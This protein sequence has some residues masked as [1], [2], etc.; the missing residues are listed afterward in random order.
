MGYIEID[1]HLDSHLAAAWQISMLTLD[2]AS[3]YGTTSFRELAWE[4]TENPEV[5]SPLAPEETGGSK[6]VR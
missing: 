1:L 2:S 5:S 6:S 3:K 4:R